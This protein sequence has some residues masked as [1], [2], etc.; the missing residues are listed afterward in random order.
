[1]L[2][3]L[4]ICILGLKDNGQDSVEAPEMAFVDTLASFFES[5]VNSTNNLQPQKMSDVSSSSYGNTIGCPT[6]LKM[7]SASTNGCLPKVAASGSVQSEASS[8]SSPTSSICGYSPAAVG[9]NSV[10]SVLDVSSILEQTSQP[11]V[12]TTGSATIGKEGMLAISIDV[13]ILR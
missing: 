7:F 1:M 8:R 9:S 3:K 12:A 5:S 11:N 4:F 6:K 2:C 13:C 10:T